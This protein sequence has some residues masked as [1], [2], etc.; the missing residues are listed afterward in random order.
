MQTRLTLLLLIATSACGAPE[1]AGPELIMTGGRIYVT[2]AGDQVVSA[3]AIQGDMITALGDDATVRALATDD[4]Q[5]M[6]LN[7]AAVLAGMHDAWVDLFALGALEDRVDLRLTASP[8]DV[9]AKVRAALRNRA[10]TIVGWGWDERRWPDPTLPTASALDE[11]TTE[12]AVVLYRRSGRVAWLNSAALERAGLEAA[13]TSNGMVSGAHLEAAEDAL[14]DLGSMEA[15]EWVR[16]SLRAAAAGGVTSLGTTPLDPRQISVLE[17]LAEADITVRVGV[18]IRADAQLSKELGLL[19]LDGLGL[20]LDGPISLGLSGLNEPLIDAVTTHPPDAAA[21]AVACAAA[22]QAGLPLDVQARGDAAIELAL[23][24]AATR[25][26]IGADLL[27]TSVDVPRDA[28]FAVVPGRLA[29]DMYWLDTVL[30]SARAPRTHAYRE[31]ARHGWLAGVAS[32]APAAEIRPME[33]LRIMFTRRDREGFPLDGWQ[34]QERLAVGDSLS[35]MMAAGPLS[36]TLEPGRA[37]DLVVW[38]E[39]PFV[40]EAELRGAQ[41]MLVLVNGRVVYSRPL[42][43]PP[44]DRRQ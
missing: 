38:S 3:L 22:T 42:A 28:R 34:A 40:G 30:G 26:V 5:E 43:T 1:S 16:R 13:G 36:P 19:R 20:E 10:G 44:M 35:A 17:G 15:Q 24:C 11:V 8:R 29:N 32:D 14:L 9:Q 7:G 6:P 25:L 33:A 27:P 12:Q 37:A 23:T 21:L 31:M 41:A 39:D 2:P 18:R 4:T